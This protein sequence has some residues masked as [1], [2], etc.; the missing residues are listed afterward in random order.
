MKSSAC[1][2]PP[3]AAAA[4]AAPWPAAPRRFGQ[5]LGAKGGKNKRSRKAFTLQ[6]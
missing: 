6:G 1:R 2:L 4:A 5:N 3:A